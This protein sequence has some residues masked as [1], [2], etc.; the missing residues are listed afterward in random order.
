MAEELEEAARRAT[1]NI[2][3]HWRFLSDACRSLVLASNCQ[4]RPVT[5]NK[6]T[7]LLYHRPRGIPQGQVT[8]TQMKDA[9][10]A[11]LRKIR[12][13]GFG[14]W[15]SRQFAAMDRAWTFTRRTSALWRRLL[16]ARIERP[17]VSSGWFV[18]TRPAAGCDA[19]IAVSR[20]RY[21][22]RPFPMSLVCLTKVDRDLR[23]LGSRR[24]H[25]E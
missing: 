15:V 10:R 16:P 6:K 24:L 11:T 19:W 3:K 22:R 7:A 13:V 14:S 2:R 25:E 9:Y 23:H 5:R 12:V 17:S 4:N 8:A 21:Q 20:P 1:K 18:P